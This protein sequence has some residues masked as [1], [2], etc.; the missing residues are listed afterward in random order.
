MQNHDKQEG[1]ARF[2]WLHGVLGWGLTSGLI[3]ITLISVFGRS[4]TAFPPYY[5]LIALII[6][7]ACG[8]F[9][10]A[11]IWRRRRT[12]SAE[13]SP[14]DPVAVSSLAPPK[15]AVNKVSEE[16][17]LRV[18][19][20]PAIRIAWVGLVFFGCLAIL[21]LFT[22]QIVLF[23]IFVVFVSLCLAL[24]LTSGKVEMN[25]NRVTLYIPTGRHEILWDEVRHI[26]TDQH[27]GSIVFC[28]ASSK[29]V[30]VLG[31]GWWSGKDKGQMITLLRSEMNRR[32]IPVKVTV[33]ALF[34][35]S[36]NSRTERRC[37]L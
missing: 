28:G 13:S 10:G 16:D 17:T 23:P 12:L 25:S 33:K 1:R 20:Q 36:K 32:S 5:W 29:R 26:E 30:S 37:P 35:L 22:G 19:M 4:K 18:N 11:Y 21:C 6:F 2:I 31:P 24:R 15:T 34:R 27:W 9:W 7:P 3:W 14:V 8:Y